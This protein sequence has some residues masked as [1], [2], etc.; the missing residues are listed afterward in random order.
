MKEDGVSKRKFTVTMDPDLLFSADEVQFYNKCLTWAAKLENIIGEGLSLGFER[1]GAEY[2]HCSFWLEGKPIA[3]FE[4][5]IFGT[6]FKAKRIL[7]YINAERWNGEFVTTENT[8]EKL[9]KGG[10]RIVFDKKG[11][12][13]LG[14]ANCNTVRAE[15]LQ[16]A[17]LANLR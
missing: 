10:A 11:R 17:D 7:G 14:A 9:L 13:L 8:W 3:T 16:Q 15:S 6:G 2:V 1:H 4:F 12:G 5:G